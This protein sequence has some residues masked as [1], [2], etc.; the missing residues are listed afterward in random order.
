MSP[1]PVM[2][3]RQRGAAL[4]VGLILLMVL[5]VLAISTVRTASLELTMTGNAQ[6][7][8]RAFQLAES[9]IAETLGAIDSRARPLPADCAEAFGSEVRLEPLA[10]SY[11][12]R[13]CFV[14]STPP[15]TS[16]SSLGSGKL[17]EDHY[18]V[19]S[20]G[21]TDQRGARAQHVQ[22]LSRLAPEG[23]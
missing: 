11:A 18:E 13:V 20:T 17:R 12:T 15:L 10:G 4:V 1:P 9:G 22:G 8:Q 21:R 7:R 5:T 3:V 23:L 19:T 16:G 2:P 6:F 14:G